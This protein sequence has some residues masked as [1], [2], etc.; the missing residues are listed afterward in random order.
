[1]FEATTAQYLVI[2]KETALVAANTIRADSISNKLTDDNDELGVA[3]AFGVHFTKRS[4]ILTT[5]AATL[6]NTT[7][8]RH[9]ERSDRSTFAC[10]YIK[11]T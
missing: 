5:T 11:R 4:P 7:R 3:E 8:Q 10:R 9:Y 2:T 1:M 6:T